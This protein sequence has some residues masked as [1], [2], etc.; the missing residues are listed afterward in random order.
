MLQR[1]VSTTGL[2]TDARKKPF[3]TS[4]PWTRTTA[5][6]QGQGQ[7]QALRCQLTAPLACPHLPSPPVRSMVSSVGE[8]IGKR[9]EKEKRW[10]EGPEGFPRGGNH[11]KH[12][13]LH[14]STVPPELH[15]A[16]L[17]LRSTPS[18]PPSTHS[19]LPLL[20]PPTSFLPT[21]PSLLTPVHTVH[22][23][24]LT[25]PDPHTGSHHPTHSPKPHPCHAA[26]PTRAS[27][28]QPPDT[29]VQHNHC[30]SMN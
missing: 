30:G 17:G 19:S 3:G 18:H 16:L 29:S 5:P 24:H 28:V 12:S 27:S 6:R 2:P 25:Q 4:W 7:A 11:P 26:H 22:S 14:P 23:I 13:A 21:L 20:F 10:A 1:C 8:E 15:P 9:S